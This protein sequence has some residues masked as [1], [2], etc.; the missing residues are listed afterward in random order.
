[1]RAA[2]HQDAGSCPP[3]N[4]FERCKLDHTQYDYDGG[5]PLLCDQC[6]RPARPFACRGYRSRIRVMRTPVMERRGPYTQDICELGNKNN[7]EQ[8]P[9]SFAGGGRFL[10]SYTYGPMGLIS[11][12]AEDPDD[13]FGDAS[14]INNRD[15]YYLRDATGGHVG[16]LFDHDDNAQT[17]SQPSF[18]VYDSFG[19]NMSTALSGAGSF[20]WRGGEG[21]VSDREPN[22][23]HMQARHYDPTLGR[24]IQAD[25]LM[26]ASFTTQGMNR[27]IYCENDSVNMSDPSGQGVGD[28]AKAG[29]KI[30]LAI[31]FAGVGLMMIAGAFGGLSIIGAFGAA[32]AIIA[33][34]LAFLSA[35]LGALAPLFSDHSTRCQLELL[36]HRLSL[37]SLAGNTVS[38]V[39]MA[40]TAA[41]KLLDVVWDMVSWTA[42]LVGAE[43][44]EGW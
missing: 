23:V 41:T 42:D 3:G 31:L 16:V 8:Y 38:L 1:M 18:T 2:T 22:L 15:Y 28:W 19:N 29:L 11:R 17:L 43:P 44:W 24:F 5:V 4:V 37:A 34:C 27:Y 39:A 20:A 14:L 40:P 12:T 35:F 25:S 6:W 33:I 21:S 32:L 36:S 30:G 7:P 9:S 13:N 10:A 26:L